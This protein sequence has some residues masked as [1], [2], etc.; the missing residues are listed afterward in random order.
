MPG[1][2]ACYGL[3]TLVL[4]PGAFYGPGGRYAFNRLFFEDPLKGLPVQVC[5]GRR[6]TFPVHVQDVAQGV[7]LALKQGRPGEVYNVSGRSLSHREINSIVDRL[8]GYHIRWLSVSA[9]MMLAL[10]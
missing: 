1:G 4:R 8:L 2:G 9:W 5:R 7:D 6:I 3:P 10:A